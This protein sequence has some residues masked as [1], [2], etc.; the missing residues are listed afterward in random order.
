MT[1]VQKI[2]GL[3]WFLHKSIIGVCDSA[4]KVD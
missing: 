4:G 2:L 3:I 1:G